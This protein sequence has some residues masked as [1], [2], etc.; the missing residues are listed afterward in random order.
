MVLGGAVKVSDESVLGK[1]MEKQGRRRDIV[2]YSSRETG[3][4]LV[5]S[6]IRKK[7]RKKS[8][9]IPVPGRARTCR[10]ESPSTGRSFARLGGERSRVQTRVSLKLITYSIDFTVTCLEKSMSWSRGVE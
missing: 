7:R 10:R 8:L 2:L 4:S 1:R 6:R 5:S 3:S 9:L